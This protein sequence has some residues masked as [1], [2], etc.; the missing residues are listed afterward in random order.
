MAARPWTSEEDEKLRQCVK[1]GLLARQAAK[2]LGRTSNS[3]RMRLRRLGETWAGLSFEERRRAGGVVHGNQ[4]KAARE[5]RKARA[6]TMW[7]D[8]MSRREIAKEMCLNISA[9]NAYCSGLVRPA[10]PRKP[11]VKK[12]KPPRPKAI[13]KRRVPKFEKIADAVRSYHERGL[14]QAEVA[15]KLGVTTATVRRAARFAGIGRWVAY[16]PRPERTSEPRRINYSTVGKPML[17]KVEMP[18]IVAAAQFLGRWYRPVY[19]ATISDPTA[20]KGHYVVGRQV[21]PVEKMFE[22]ARERGF[23][24]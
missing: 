5:I 2:K 20:P 14:E 22:L 1:D 21:L 4:A 11:K 18:T 9:I 19:K 17:A 12:P 24:A 3:I 23:A 7:H 6:I 13:A 8:G 10:E 15:E 16:A